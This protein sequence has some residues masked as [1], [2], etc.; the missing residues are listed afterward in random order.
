MKCSRNNLLRFGQIC[1]PLV[2]SAGCLS[3]DAAEVDLSKLPPASTNK[4]DF[5]HDIQ[6]ILADNCLRCHGPEKPKSQFRLDNR[7]AA[8]KGGDNGVD[9]IP[10]KSAESPL[11]HYVAYLVEDSEMPPIGKGRQ[12]TPADVSILRA[13]IDQGAPWNTAGVSNLLNFAFSPTLGGTS[14]SGNKQKFRELNWQPGGLDGGLDHFELFKQIDPDTKLFIHGHVT[15]DDYEVNLAL[16]RSGLGFI[17]SGW[18]QYRK[19]YDDVGGF[20]PAFVNAA[21]S[22]GQDLHLDIGKAWVDLGLMVPDWPRVVAGYQYD[23]RRGNEATTEWNYVGTNTVSGRNLAPASQSLHES[24]HTFKVDVDYE[25][26]GVTIEDR[27]RGEFYRLSTVNTNV[28]SGLVAQKTSD[29]TRYFQGANTFRLEKQ[30]TSWLLASAGYLYSRLNA[31]SAFQLDYPVLLES[32]TLPAITLERES[33]VGNANVLLGPVA[34]FTLS[35]GVL[36]DWTG[37][38]GFGPGVLNEETS[39]LTDIFLPFSVDS[40]YDERTFEETATLRYSKIP[41]TSLF[42]EER[43]QQQ[44]ISQLDQFASSVDILNKAVFTQHTV[45]S[46][47]QNDVRAGFETS[48]WRFISVNADYRH[49]DD[50][51][52]YNS[53]K[54]LQPVLTSYPTF[55]T[56]RDLRTDE[57]EARLVLHPAAFFKTTLSYQYQTTGYDLTTRSLNFFGT[58]VS[59]GGELPSGAERSQTYSISATLT[60]IPRLALDASASYSDSTLTTPTDGSPALVPYQGNVYTVMADGTYIFSQHVDLFAAYMFSAA[61]YGQNNFVSGLPL[62]ISYHRHAVQVGLSRRFGKN[63]SAKLQYRLD[64][65]HEPSSGG[66]NNYVAHAIFGTLSF[67]FP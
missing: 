20:D 41:Y 53:S 64:C 48:P 58:L 60:P 14:V 66:A 9:I 38:N 2:A 54:L 34:G 45:Y 8:L 39:A 18:T 36:A 47:D 44:D 55:I 67:Q 4:I 17:H 23:Y 12:L 1:F 50:G 24:V 59:P 19:Y 10:G 29:S 62:G 11:I 7:T 40:D 63:V 52:S 46:G 15:R 31:D 37:Q 49:I 43:L 26:K 3:A 21:R 33:N 57:V 35:G 61:D 16:D 32:A 22:S 5:A 25:I 42:A 51:S 56:H 28:G 27:F 6:P 13:W 65:Y 30:F